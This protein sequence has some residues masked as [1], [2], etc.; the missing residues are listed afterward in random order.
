[1]RPTQARP[2]ARTGR[3]LAR[4]TRST[5]F[6]MSWLEP[7]APQNRAPTAV[8]TGLAHFRGLSH[9]RLES[10][11]RQAG[12][13]LPG[14]AAELLERVVFDGQTCRRCEDHAVLDP[15]SVELGSCDGVRR[16]GRRARNGVTCVVERFDGR[17]YRLL[18]LVVGSA[19]LRMHCA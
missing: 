4:R 18:Q 14:A 8:S 1:V 13:Q 17:E 5:A 16:G 19:H 7:R 15:A 6:G 10:A 12:G 9:K 2:A 3:T 11:R